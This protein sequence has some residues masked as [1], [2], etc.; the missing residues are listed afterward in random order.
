M[1]YLMSV[2]CHAPFCLVGRAAPLGM[3]ALSYHALCSSSMPL[4][5]RVSCTLLYSG[6]GSTPWECLL[7]IIMHLVL[8]VCHYFVGCHAT[9]LYSGKVC[10]VLSYTL[11][12]IVC[13]Y[14]VGCHATLLYS[15]KGSAP[16]ECLTSIIMHLVQPA[17]MP[18]QNALYNIILLLFQ[19]DDLS[20]MEIN[21]IRLLLTKALD[22][23]HDLRCHATE[24][25]PMA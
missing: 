5:C 7:C 2:G 3:P 14:F 12:K 9:V 22:H 21:T 17:C 20:L 16:W 25:P 10:L 23:L 11:F 13:H 24:N 15:G 1:V 6:K 8:L 18:L 4:L 19:L